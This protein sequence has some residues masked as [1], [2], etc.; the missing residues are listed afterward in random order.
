MLVQKE[1]LYY[2]RKLKVLSNKERE[3]DGMKRERVRDYQP[4]S[5]FL[6]FRYSKIL[7]PVSSSLI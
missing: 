7:L 1:N 6:V 2:C 4:F 3:I 5:A